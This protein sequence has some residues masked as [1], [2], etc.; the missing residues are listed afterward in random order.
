VVDVTINWSTPPPTRS[1]AIP[2]VV[3]DWAQWFVLAVLVAVTLMVGWK[4]WQWQTRLAVREDVRVMVAEAAP[5]IW[6]DW[7]DKGDGGGGR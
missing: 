3:N 6:E 1:A 7:T 5:F 4:A 2:A